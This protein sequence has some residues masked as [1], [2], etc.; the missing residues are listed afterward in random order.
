MRF[1]L[2][3][4]LIPALAQCQTVH[5]EKGRIAYKGSVK[6]DGVTKTELYKRAKQAL[7]KNIKAAKEEID[8][9]NKEKE[10][11]I[12]G[13][14]MRLSS[15]HGDI[16]T[17]KYTVKI[18]VKDDGYKYQVDSVYFKRTERG[19]KTIIIPSEEL[20]NVM[21]MS[22]IPAIEMEKQLNEIDMRIQQLLDLINRDIRRTPIGNGQ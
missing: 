13:G 18:A 4:L 8:I 16:K 10:E 20:V 19:G 7:L 1:L 21:D 17:L 14:R 12:V 9:E 22:G 15:T 5:I 2:F 11:I 6:I 3:L